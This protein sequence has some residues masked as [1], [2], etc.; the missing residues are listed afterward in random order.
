VRAFP[1]VWC[2]AACLGL[3]RP[4]LAARQETPPSSQGTITLEV[5]V[6]AAERGW[7]LIDRGA[8]DRLA[9]G[10]VVTFFPR[11]GGTQRGTVVELEE[12]AARV[13][14][15]DPAFAPAP[16]TRGRIE[17]PRDRASAPRR[18]PRAA[19][20]TAP[21]SGAEPASPPPVFR[22]P[23]DE[24]QSDE[25][26]LA[27]VRPVRPS[28]RPARAS[29][30]SYLALDH[31]RA[32]EDDRHDTFVRLGGGL[33]VENPFGRGDRLQADAEWNYRRV[34][35]PDDDDLEDVELRLER[36]S[37]TVG[38]TRFD[39]DS[40]QVGRFLQEGL[41]E[42]GVLDG[43]EWIVRRRNGHRFGA[44]VGYLPEPDAEFQTGSDFQ[45]AAFYE[46]VAD[47]SERL[48]FATG[49]QKTFH[50]GAADRDLVVARLQRLPR[51]GWTFF[52]TAWIDLYTDGDDAKDES[53]GV[54]QADLSLGRRFAGGSSL[55]LVYRHLEFPELE[56]NEFTPV[57]D[58]QL[59]DD[60]SERLALTHR[61]QL[62]PDT[63]LRTSL[64]AWVDE[65][66][67]GSDG[68]LGLGL[69]ELWDARDFLD[70]ALFG[71][72]AR[73]SDTLGARFSFGRFTNGGRWA[74]DYE[75]SQN[76]LDG[77]DADNDD[78][79]QHRL[80]FSR[81]HSWSAWSLSWRIEGLV[82]DDEYALQLGLYLQR[83]HY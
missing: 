48:A 73:F 70:L 42:L 39:Q 43:A 55:D 72:N 41:V 25:P 60:H 32:S 17:L 63:R 14:L 47:E 31:T 59:A 64:G 45:L 57:E 79:P 37:Y 2:L 71:S 69:R 10:D 16:G 33:V 50:N 11:E 65:D 1:L 30:T 27:R 19:P 68:E 28:E 20:P 23:D 8:S 56:R 51:E 4:V 40:L 66:E 13:E 36:L 75:L 12:R 9:L 5:R 83:S 3:G 22:N 26:L 49:Y 7:V 21:P 38:G 34:D 6:G 58:D 24:W 54:T 77:F 61:W 74:V 52:G 76:R 80:R 18:R 35:L 53:V 62:T 81:D 46:W 82:Y 29:G 15:A 67:S 44:S 78:L